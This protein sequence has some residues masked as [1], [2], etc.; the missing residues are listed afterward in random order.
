MRKVYFLLLAILLAATSHAQNVTVTGAVSG[1]GSYPDLGSAFTAINAGAQTGANILVSVVGNTTEAASATLNAGSW[2]S[3]LIAPSGGAGRTI[4]G[5]IAGPLIDLNGA[6]NVLIDGL[7]TGGNSLSISNAS[8]SNLTNTSTIRFINDASTNA[9]SN[10]TI[11]GSSTSTTLGTV[12][13]S[14]GTATGNDGNAITNCNIN[15]AGANSPVNGV[16]S[17]GTAAMENSGNTIVNCNI[18]DYFSATALTSG[19]L[20][21]ANNSGWGITGNRLFQTA[22]RTYTTANIHNGIS[23]SSGSGHTISGNIIGFASSAGTGVYTM[24]GTIATRMI[25]INV[26][27]GTAS[28]TLVQGNTVASISLATSSGAATT[29]GV[30]CGINITSG[31]VSATGNT[32]GSV[33]G[34]GSLVAI[35]TT[36]QGMVV[37]INSSSTGTILIDNNTM[38]GFTSAGATA[39]VA[40]GVSGVNVSGVATSITVT[41]NTIGNSTADNMRAGVSGTTT[42]SSIASGINQTSIPVLSNYSNNTIQNLSSYGTGT[43]GYVRGIHTGGTSSATAVATMSG[44]IINNLTTSSGLTGISSGLTAALGIQFLTGVNS[45]ISNNSISNISATNPATTNIIVAG[46]T[47][48]SSTNTVI[49]GNRIYGLTNAGTSTTLTAPATVA[50]IVVR[51]GTTGINIVNNMI[52]LGSG[53]TTNTS[54]IGIWG[55]HGST[56]DPIVRVYFNSITIEGTAAAGAMPSFAYHRGDLTATARNVTVDIRNNILINTRSGGTGIHYAIGN[57]FGATASATGWPANASNYNVL[58]AAPANI[59]HWN[60]PLTFANWQTTSAS[61]A[62]SM[63]NVALS[64]VNTATANLHIAG[65]NPPIE[66]TGTPIASVTV[67]FDGDLRSAFTPTDIGADAGNFINYPIITYTPLANS[68]ATGART[69][70]ATITDVDGVPTAGLGLPVLYWRINAGAYTAATATSLG[71]DQYQFSFGAGA[72]INDVVSYYIVAQDNVGNVGSSPALGAGGFTTNPPAAATPPTTPNSY[73]LVPTLSGTY[74]VGVGGAYTTLTAAV[75]AYNTACLGGP[76]LFN[77]IDAT[78]PSETFPITIN[79]NA[80]ASAVNTLTIK[81]TVPSTITGSNAFGIIVLNGADWVTINGSVSNT[82]NSVCPVVAASRDLT[83]SNTNS[84]TSSGVIWLGTTST[85]DPVTNSSVQNCIV[86]GNAPGTTIAGIGAGGSAVGT[87]GSDNDNLSFINNDIRACRVAIYSSG[88]SAVNKN[89]TIVINQ[90]TITAI[91]PNNVG[92]TGIYVA[93]TNN[94]TVSRNAVD[95]INRS[96]TP[97]VVGINLGF[98]AVNG[99]ATT[100]TGIADGIS[101]ATITHNTIGA[102][103]HTGTFGAVGIALGNTVSGTSLIANNM[104]TGVICN[105]TSPDMASGIVLGGGAAQVNVY[106]NTVAMQGTI[107]GTT[108]ATMVSAA[109][110]IV[111]P[112]P[113]PLDIRNNI[114]TNTQQGNTGATLRIAAVAVVQS[115]YTGL[116]SNYNDLYS[117]GAGPGTYTVGVT[118]GLTGTNRVTLANWQTETG[119]DANSLNVLPVYVSATDAHL[120][121]TNGTNWCFNAAGVNI[122][123]IVN[124]IDCESRNNPPD[125]GADEF[126]ANGFVVNT[127]ILICAGGTADLTAAS[128]TSGSMGG[129]SFTYFTDAAA[130]IAVGVPTAVGTGTYYIKAT[131]GSC[132][133]VLPVVV[134]LHPAPTAFTV[135]GG[136]SYCVGGSGVVVGLDDSETGVNYQLQLNGSDI[137]SP[138]AGTG[139]AISFGLQSG[140]GTYTVV[141]TNTTTTCTGA[142]T[143]SV[144]ISTNP[145]PVIGSVVTEPSSCVSSDGAINLTISGAPGPYTFSWSTVGGSGLTAGAEDQTGL[146]VGQYTVVVTASNGCQETLVVTLVGPGGCGVCP[147]MG[148]LTTSPVGVACAG[149][150][151]TITAS[152]LAAMG[153]TYGVEF[154]VSNSPLVNPY[155]GG[156]TIGTVANGALGGGGTTA[157]ITTSSLL[158][159]N[160]FVYAILTPTPLDPS[161]RPFEATTLTI[162][163]VPTVN[164]ITNQVLCNNGT[165]T[166]VNFVGSPIGTTYSWTNNNTSIGLAASGS[167]APSI[168]NPVSATTTMGSGFG[169]S[170]ANTINGVGLSSFPSLMA[171]H[172]ATIP[173]NSWA[174]QAPATTGTITFNLGGNF[175][176]NGF[177]FWN[178]NGGGPGANGTTGIRDVVILSSTDGV[179]FTP[180]AG[181]PGTFAQ[182]TGNNVDPKAPETFSFAPVSAAF[183]RFT[184]INNHGDPAQTGFGEVAF[185][186]AA[187]IPAFVATNAGTA[188]AVATVTV[189][190]SYTNAG[191]TCTGTPVTFT[192][193]VNP[194]PTITPVSNQVVCAGASIPP[195]NFVVSTTGGTNSIAWTNSNPAI[196]IPASGTGNLTG[197]TATNA[198][199]APISGT[200]TVTPTFTNGSVSCA[201]PSITYTVTVNP[202]ATVNAVAN[203]TVCNGASTTAINFSSPTTG[204]T[205]VY[206]WTN[207]TPS[208]GLAASG[209]GNIA[210]FNAVNAGTTPVVATITVTPSYTNGA[211]TCTGTPRTFTITVNPTPNAVAT[212]STQTICSGPITTIVLSGAVTG[213]TYSWTRNNTANVTGIAASG[214]G[215]ISGSLTNTTLVQQTVTFTITPTAN[216]CPGTPITATVILNVAPTITCPANITAASTVGACTATVT[217]TPTVTGSPAPTLTYS[218][219][220]ATTGSGSGTG[221]GLAF[222]VGVTTV[223]VTATNACGTVSCSFTITVTDSQLPVISAQP[224]NRTVCAGANAVFSVTAATSP[225]ANGPIAYQWQQWNGT[226]WTNIAGATT[227]TYTVNNTTVSMNTNTFRVVLTGL[228]SVVNSSAASLYVNPIPTVVVSA[229]PPANIL[230]NQTTTLTATANPS[231][232]S[233]AWSFN[234]TAIP[235]AT[236]QSYGPIGID[237]LGSY[238]VTYTSTAGCTATSADFQVTGAISDV[239]WVYPNPNRGIFQVRFYNQS[240]EPATI[241]VFNMKGQKVYERKVVTGATTY[242]QI[243]VDLGMKANGVYNVQLVN[244]SGKVLGAKQIIVEA[245]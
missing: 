74:T 53:Q 235:G 92:E 97:D 58:N 87:G 224:V 239:L 193:T 80:G 113:G 181:A 3:M 64:F 114:F 5:S 18:S 38:G 115:A 218:L 8:T 240:N 117:T 228:C 173:T 10:C 194:T 163:N 120:V 221:S 94:V 27:V 106:N 104:I 217:Y 141:A 57:N 159:G 129:L 24:S 40:G 213:T 65:L 146:S 222:N 45:T 182:A 166:A 174:S 197:Y 17:A 88:A 176:V 230:P 138:V 140:V 75:N 157:A 207:N 177:A 35:P 220:G 93:F 162:N 185:S 214:T 156:T 108:A 54:F 91:A 210:A 231:G 136:G 78:Y 234:G 14:T 155:V 187:G 142:M 183:I 189:T 167:N 237:A 219:A 109:L 25:A 233:Y 205:I 103:V 61:D 37:G 137:G 4:T 99:M 130:T 134:G 13:F 208:I 245:F 51:S 72:A 172:D 147:V 236:G 60:G 123:A 242:S 16:F 158:P 178:Q 112:T 121:N 30:L 36:T 150:N 22:S 86:I 76:V 107:T 23:I 223:T 55:N 50:G 41:N 186:R 81:P 133:I 170:L 152:G 56:P 9:V 131:N 96:A 122:A 204:G 90:N 116:V 102:I 168:I 191:V 33:T 15:A 190:P 184:V 202:T 169:T 126:V 164:A 29:N 243:Q 11:S 100:G 105:A 85:S 20:I 31:N 7:N 2:T 225:S 175:L 179:T 119:G 12:F 34:T 77:L 161:C 151:V 165:T 145:L 1:N 128:V 68:C 124:D 199:N 171:N 52:S 28:T 39:A 226:A 135:T 125:I 48:G 149:S 66:G 73:S 82:V 49:S 70:T 63:S 203:Q 95:N 206:N 196:G 98:G 43:G 84:G 229:N 111:A 211:V 118:G 79:A 110:S 139:S 201:G 148:S 209:S 143:G 244:G 154:K 212:P 26:A 188:P 192:Y 238:R 21:G 47:H 232:G 200:I 62:N 144:T 195:V 42:G 101:N 89:E 59:G 69:L 44:N 198:T 46:I 19:I 132:S 241:L 180:I 83:I 127:P 216:G 6:D 153:V 160:Y 215:N 32:I 67:D 71:G 227:A